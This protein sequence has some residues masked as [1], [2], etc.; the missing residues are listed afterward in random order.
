MVIRNVIIAIK[1]ALEEMDE[2]YCRL[3]RMD[4]S[5]IEVTEPVKKIFQRKNI[6]R[7]L[8]RVN[9]IISFGN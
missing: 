8:S 4:Y 9:F 1:V 3:S 5:K 6:W 2:E 7:N